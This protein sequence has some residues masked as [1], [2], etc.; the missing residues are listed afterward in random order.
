M[1][2]LRKIISLCIQGCSGKLKRK[3]LLCDGPMTLIFYKTYTNLVGSSIGCNIQPNSFLL[4][5]FFFLS[6]FTNSTIRLPLKYLEIKKLIDF[7]TLYTNFYWNQ[8][9]RFTPHKWY[10]IYCLAYARFT[11]SFFISSSPS[12]IVEHKYP[13]FL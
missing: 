5:S 1:D 13:R 10:S 7:S 8:L 9:K 2:V 12:N 6:H 11:F 4:Y 3:E